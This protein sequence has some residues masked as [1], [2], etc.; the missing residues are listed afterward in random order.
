MSDNKIKIE[1]G[2]TVKVAFYG[3]QITLSHRAEVL[4]MPYATGDSWHVKDV[5][6]GAIHYV[7]EGCTFS[8]VAKNES[9]DLW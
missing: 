7:S 3:A 1:I 4:Y 8:L 9:D 2:D 5:D 6:T